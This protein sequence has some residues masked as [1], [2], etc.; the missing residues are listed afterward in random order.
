VIS[1]PLNGMLSFLN[2]Y[3]FLK[4]TQAPS[5]SWRFIFTVGCHSPL[6]AYENL[7]AISTSQFMFIS[8]LP[9]DV[10]STSS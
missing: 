6:R 2:I 10:Q 7:Y 8:M 1:A 5:F 4:L 9:L 3:T